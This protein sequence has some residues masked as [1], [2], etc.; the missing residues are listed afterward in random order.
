MISRPEINQRQHIH[1]QRHPYKEKQVGTVKIR[2]HIHKH[3]IR[4][5]NHGKH[6]R[7]HKKQLRL[8]TPFLAIQVSYESM[9]D[10]I[11]V[12]HLA[13][14]AHQRFTAVQPVIQCDNGS[15]RGGYKYRDYGRIYVVRLAGEFMR[16]LPKPEKVQGNK[17]YSSHHH[18]RRNLLDQTR[19]RREIT[20]AK[21]CMENL[22]Q[23]IEP[24]IN[25]GKPLARHNRCK[26]REHR[27]QAHC[28]RPVSP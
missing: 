22:Q 10:N 16:I 24:D 17:G 7:Q 1:H 19:A 3:V 6:Q 13:L 18:N 14:L 15:H 11:P 9:L 23:Y 2:I 28:N 26:H 8:I 12:A 27:E 20:L 21:L 4:P 25:R 5:V